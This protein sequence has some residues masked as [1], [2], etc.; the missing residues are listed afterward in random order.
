[1]SEIDD[2]YS[3]FKMN[4]RRCEAE[5]YRLKDSISNELKK[6]KIDEGAYA[7]LEK[8]IEDYMRE[9]REQILKEQFGNLPS[10]MKTELYS[11]IEN[12][13]ISE[14]EYKKFKALLGKAGGIEEE[15][16]KELGDMVK[17]WMEDYRKP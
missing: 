11:M 5:L 14:E 6:G 13:Q 8:R 15:E 2:T 10:S 3:S 1:M 17:K 9:I 16:K 12:A 7:V 4:S